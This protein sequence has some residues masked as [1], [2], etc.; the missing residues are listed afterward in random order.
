MLFELP[1][2]NAE[3]LYFAFTVSDGNNGDAIIR[4]HLNVAKSEDGHMVE[5]F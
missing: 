4:R 1:A 5:N 2:M 3:L